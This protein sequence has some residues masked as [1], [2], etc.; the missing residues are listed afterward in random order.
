MKDHRHREAEKG[1]FQNC[2]N[3]DKPF[4]KTRKDRQCCCKNCAN[5]VWKKSHRKQ[6]NEQRRNSVRQK[7]FDKKYRELYREYY[8]EYKRQQRIKDN[9]SKIGGE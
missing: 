8:M 3:C 6:I 1:G 4:L 7:A 9:V 5:S 2:L